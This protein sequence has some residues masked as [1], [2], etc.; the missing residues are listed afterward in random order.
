MALAKY[1]AY[2]QHHF[3]FCTYVLLV[4]IYVLCYRGNLIFF[5][6]E[7]F[8]MVMFLSSVLMAHYNPKTL[9]TLLLYALFFSNFVC[10][11]IYI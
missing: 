1:V 6:D 5:T 11:Y 2:F 4:L 8:I 9:L 7:P 10:V 3:R